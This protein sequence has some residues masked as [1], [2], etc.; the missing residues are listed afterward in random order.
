MNIHLNY[1][2]SILAWKNK[3][4]FLKFN[5]LNPSYPELSAMNAFI[6][7]LSIIQVYV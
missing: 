6:V 5:Y 4:I 3:H 1:I 2:K 7:F